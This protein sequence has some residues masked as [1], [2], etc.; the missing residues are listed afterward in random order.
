MR[1]LDLV[2]NVEISKEFQAEATAY[3]LENELELMDE[4]TAAHSRG[5]IQHYLQGEHPPD[6]A[7]RQ[8]FTAADRILRAGRIEVAAQD[9]A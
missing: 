8:I 9:E 2:P 6:T 5:Y 3:L 1:I 7:I 4:E